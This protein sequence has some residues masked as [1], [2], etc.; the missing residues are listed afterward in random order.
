MVAQQNS[1]AISEKK[2]G[3]TFTPKRDAEDEKWVVPKVDAEFK[4]NEANAEFHQ[5]RE[6]IA[7]FWKYDI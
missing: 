5:R 2:L 7:Y 1:V 6:W 3:H 4:L